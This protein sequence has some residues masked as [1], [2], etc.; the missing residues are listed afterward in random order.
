QGLH[1]PQQALLGMVLMVIPALLMV[2]TI[3]FRSFKTIDMGARRGY[4]VLIGVAAFL[5]LVVTYPHEVLILMAYAY[6]LSGII[7]LLRTRLRPVDTGD[8]RTADASAAAGP[9]A[10]S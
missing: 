1:T 5:A 6:L 7:G 10:R 4:Q 3:K 8:A 9:H 2:S